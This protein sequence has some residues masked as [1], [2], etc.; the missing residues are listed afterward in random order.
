[1]TEAGRHDFA[2]Q[3]FPSTGSSDSGRK[4]TALDLSPERKKT[5]RN[6]VKL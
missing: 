1:M 5:E 6:K 4:G 2:D 3:F